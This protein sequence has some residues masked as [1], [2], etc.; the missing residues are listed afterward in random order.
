MRAIII[1]E[2]SQCY[3]SPLTERTPHPL[4]PLAGK[5]IL[6]HALEVLHHSS[7]RE[8]DVVSPNL[9][10]Q[11][12]SQLNVG[13]LTGMVVRFVPAVPDL[14]HSS[15]HS[16]IVG[17][18]DIADTN[19]DDALED[20]GDLHLHA[21]IPIRMTVHGVPVAVLIPPCFGQDAVSW[22]RPGSRY[23]YGDFDDQISC[24]WS[25]IH[26]TE[27]IQLPINPEHL[28]S[29]SSFENY[30]QANFDLLCGEFSYMKPTGREYLSG[31]RS[32]PK[33]RVNDS[34]IQS[35]HGYFGSYCRID[36]SARLHGDVI[37]GDR[38]VVDKG[39]RI[40]DSI[41]FDKTY[42]GSNIDCRKAIVDGN[43]LI[44][45]DTGVCLEVDDPVLFGAIA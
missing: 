15:Q 36:K 13:P 21:M 40:S 4:L 25:E 12:E 33:A 7:I 10:V 45:I 9:H 14:Q 6:M 28:I 18:S 23:R 30:Y 26:R 35:Q 27:A 17:L 1:A 5:P 34:S 22:S 24:D 42:I 29:T 11:L 19:W 43:L 31:H 3:L 16:L 44:K 8:V 38:A 32:A 37:I 41:I 2:H 39:A 20:L